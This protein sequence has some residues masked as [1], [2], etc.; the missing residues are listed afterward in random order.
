NSGRTKLSRRSRPATR[1]SRRR[2]KPSAAAAARRAW[3]VVDDSEWSMRLLPVNSYGRWGVGVSGGWPLTQPRSSPAQAP[4][5]C[6]S[7]DHPIPLPGRGV[8]AGAVW[9][10]SL[11]SRGGG[12]GGREKRVGVMRVL[13][14][15]RAP[16]G[17]AAL[18][19]P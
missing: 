1:A 5:P 3:V 2:L 11:F 10:F 7:P 16:A 9:L 12:G 17:R 8:P 19:A 6:P 18:T 14:G 15:G 13:G 4:H